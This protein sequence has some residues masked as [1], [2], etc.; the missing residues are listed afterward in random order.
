MGLTIPFEGTICWRPETAYGTAIS[1]TPFRVSDK[2]YDVRIDYGKTF[3]ELRGISAPSVCGFISQ[4]SDYTLHV[5]WVSQSTGNSLATHCIN[6]T[7]TGDM[8]SL[9]FN[10]G[11]NVKGGTKSYYLVKGAKCKS[12]NIKGNTGSEIIYTADFSCCSVISSAAETVTYPATA[13]GTAY[14]QF[15]KA[16]M[17]V[18]KNTST[19][20]ATCVDGLDVTINHNIQDYWQL[21]SQ[22]KKA[23]IPGQLD[24]AGT[25]D[26][27]LDDGG[28]AFAT[29]INTELTNIFINQNYTT[30]GKLTFVT[31][32]WDGFTVDVSTGN[33]TL[34]TGQKFMAK[35]VTI[36]T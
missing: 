3:K 2:V 20:I 11:I 9:G 7:S 10:V 29:A 8:Q 16:G 14:G 17:V 12:F 36:T 30:F 32:R 21:D 6:R 23:A 34:I 1:G 19:V 24:V 5:E 18:A 27:S 35:S 28:N 4:P 26:I 13:L 25:I 15:N 33:D 31:A 22:Y